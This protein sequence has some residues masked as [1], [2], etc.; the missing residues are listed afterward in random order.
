MLDLSLLT[1]GAGFSG[2]DANGLPKYERAN[3]IWSMRTAFPQSTSD[4][5]RYWN[6][7]VN[8]WLTFYIFYRLDSIDS[9]ASKVILTRIASAL[10]HGLYP[11]YYCF[12][13]CSAIV[14]NVIDAMRLTLPTYQ[15]DKPNRFVFVCW[16]LITVVPIDSF[17]GIFFMQLDIW[18][19]L[20]LLKALNYFP[21]I[22]TAVYF[23][24]GQV[25]LRTIGIKQSEKD[26]RNAKKKKSE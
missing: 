21:I 16:F 26:K 5:V 10:F 12:F 18:K 22:L 3:N 11:S 19:G 2:C 8:E 6:M 7:T 20:A 15:R 13:F 17:G 23:V 9:K 1:S 14:T 24:I 25:L 4:V